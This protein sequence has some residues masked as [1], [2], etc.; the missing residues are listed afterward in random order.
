MSN[1]LRA[2]YAACTG[3]YSIL[4]DPEDADCVIGQSFGTSYGKDSPNY[5]L[6]NQIHHE[7]DGHPKI[8][9]SEIASVYK[10]ISQG[11]KVDFIPEGNPSSTTGGGLTSWDVLLQA[12]SFMKEM[13]YNNPIIIAQAFHVGRIAMQATKLGMNPIVPEGLTRSFDKDSEQ[14]WTRNRMLWIP[15]ELAG[16]IILKSKGKL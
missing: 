11:G 14:L 10:D 16:S 9:Q 1:S 12:V 8:L 13:G 7:H 3:K 4:G 6:A 2:N 5:K 15:R